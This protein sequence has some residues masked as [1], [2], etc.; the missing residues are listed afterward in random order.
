LPVRTKRDAGG[1]MVVWLVL[2]EGLVAAE[3]RYWPIDRARRCLPEDELPDGWWTDRPVP[4]TTVPPRTEDL[5]SETDPLVVGDDIITVYNGTA[6]LNRLL[7]WGRGRF[8][9]AGLTPPPIV[10][11]TFTLYSEY[12]DD[13]GARYRRTDGGGDLSFCFGETL[14]CWDENCTHFRREVRRLVLHEMAH[15]WIDATLDEGAKQRFADHA[16]LDAWNDKSVFWDERAVEHAAETLAWG[17]MDRDLAV[18]QIGSPTAEQLTDDFRL[19]T[20]ID[21]LIKTDDFFPTF[22]AP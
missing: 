19:L 6:N 15:A 3:T 14:V 2:R 21:P 18:I 13:I 17:L 1:E 7:A 4:T 12:C 11:A 5:D 16:G 10:S 9:A 20:G 22:G 8:E